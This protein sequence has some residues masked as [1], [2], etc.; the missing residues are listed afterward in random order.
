[1]NICRNGWG[2]Y[3][4]NGYDIQPDIKNG[5]NGWV[6]KCDLDEPDGTVFTELEY[7]IDYCLDN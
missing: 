4:V 5:K 1:M 7:A 2:G 3:E 6:V